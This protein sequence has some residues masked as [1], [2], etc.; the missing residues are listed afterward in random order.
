MSF[1]D[2][3]YLTLEAHHVVDA[4]AIGVL[5]ETFDCLETNT[6]G[7]REFFRNIDTAHIQCSAFC[8]VVKEPKE[9]Y[10]CNFNAG[11]V[12]LYREF[13]KSLK[14]DEDTI[15]GCI[16]IGDNDQVCIYLRKSLNLPYDNLITNFKIRE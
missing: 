6:D 1:Q 16:Y 3:I 15:S 8:A 2:G 11:R 7:L 10:K 12:F 5:K 14:V 9:L 4:D 13:P